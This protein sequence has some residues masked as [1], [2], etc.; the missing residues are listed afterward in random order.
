MKITF[1]NG[2]LQLAFYAYLKSKRYPGIQYDNGLAK[3]SSD[4]PDEPPAP[5]ITPNFT[6]ELDSRNNYMR[7]HCKADSEWGKRFIEFAEDFKDIT[8]YDYEL[9]EEGYVIYGSY[10]PYFCLENYDAD[11]DYLGSYL[12]LTYLLENYD[13]DV[14]EV[15]ENFFE[16]YEL[17][18]Y[19]VSELYAIDPFLTAQMFSLIDTDGYFSE[20]A[21]PDLYAPDG[22]FVK[23]DNSTFIMSAN[24]LFLIMLVAA[25]GTEF[26]TKE[27]DAETVATD[28]FSAPLFYPLIKDIPHNSIDADLCDAE[29]GPELLETATQY[30]MHALYDGD[31]TTAIT[32]YA[33][34]YTY[35][36]NSGCF[37][38]FVNPSG[39]TRCLL[40]SP[41]G[42][43]F[44]SIAMALFDDLTGLSSDRTL[45]VYTYPRQGV[46][47]GCAV[48]VGMVAVCTSDSTK[49]LKPKN[50]STI[51]DLNAFTTSDSGLA[52][53][54]TYL[55]TSD[56]LRTFMLRFY[57]EMW[58]ASPFLFLFMFEYIANTNVD[59]FEGCFDT[60]VSYSALKTW[61]G[62]G[63]YAV[64]AYNGTYKDGL[65]TAM[66][67]TN[68]NITDSSMDATIL[69]LSAAEQA[70]VAHILDD[71]A[72]ELI[73][74]RFGGIEEFFYTIS[75]PDM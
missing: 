65:I 42:E 2:L 74:A 15:D 4:Q 48:D 53:I 40:V 63:S 75:D 66:N 58:Y 55:K 38:T 69:G 54:P 59:I 5:S 44:N 27:F 22:G 7:I 61:F 28:F 49:Y 45:H 9:P 70:K 25:Y 13:G 51:K 31:V 39:F 43:K 34:D 73:E 17:I 64:G 19:G 56:R 46:A 14:P 60:G 52:Q 68:G 16:I 67:D 29:N 71:A 12:R 11:F 41:K 35:T 50:I 72:V 3:Q 30:L 32:F 33:P 23:E 36:N 8:G 24:Q 62:W 21:H 1:D 26:F 18:Y 20:Y 10:Y 37:D 6:L 57:Q 47:G